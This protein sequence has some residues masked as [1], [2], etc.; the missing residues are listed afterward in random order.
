M[1]Y[2]KRILNNRKESPVQKKYPTD[3]SD[4]EREIVELV[5]RFTMTSLERILTLVR[6]V[7]YIERSKIEGDVV[8]CGV[9]KGGSMMAIAKRLCQLKSNSRKL[10]LYDTFSGM[11]EPGIED[12]DFM[13]RNANE[14]LKK[15]SSDKLNSHIWAY[16]SLEEVKSNVHSVGYEEQKFEYISGK[17][18]DTLPNS[19]HKSISLLRLDTDWYSSTY[20]E[21]IHLFPLLS[22]GG[23]LIIDDYGYWK[24]ARKAVDQYFNEL[25]IQTFLHRIDDTGRILIKE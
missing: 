4:E 25:S 16:S 23:V 1:N 7:D 3:M 17:V 11:S 24:G 9:W 10:Y 13:N 8:E 15:D 21:L 5:E 2:F 18:E 14:L 19:K 6:A 22:K 12:T 20:H